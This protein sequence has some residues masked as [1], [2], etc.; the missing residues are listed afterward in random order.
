VPPIV[1]STATPSVS[2]SPKKRLLDG[3]AVSLESSVLSSSSSR[4]SVLRDVDQS[5]VSNELIRSVKNFVEKSATEA[6]LLRGGALHDATLKERAL[7]VPSTGD[8]AR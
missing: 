8:F 7:V 1:T 5:V 4:S 3:I 6:P 2:H